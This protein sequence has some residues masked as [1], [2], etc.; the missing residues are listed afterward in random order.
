MSIIEESPSISYEQL[1]W[2]YEQYIHDY[3]FLQHVMAVP[4]PEEFDP[5]DYTRYDLQVKSQPNYTRTFGDFLLEGQESLSVCVE[6]MFFTPERC[7]TSFEEFIEL[8]KDPVGSIVIM[9]SAG[10]QKI[11]ACPELYL[12]FVPSNARIGVSRGYLGTMNY[13]HVY[14]DAY[15]HPEHK[16][17]EKD[18]IFFVQNDKKLSYYGTGVTH[19]STAV[20]RTVYLPKDKS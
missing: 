4:N 9:E 14:S 10:V 17:L 12:A 20:Y 5:A 2:M 11:I 8:S 1:G 16:V 6:R 19:D 13:T 3:E 7:N 15:R 18:G